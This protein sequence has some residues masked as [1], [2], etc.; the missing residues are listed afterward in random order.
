MAQGKYIARM[1]A[2][3]IALPDRIEKQADFLSLHPNIAVL[4]GAM[5]TF[6]ENVQSEILALPT[7]D[8]E[9]KLIYF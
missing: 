2:D 9:I 3:D 6:G 1:D 5:K 4:G 8:N 7:E